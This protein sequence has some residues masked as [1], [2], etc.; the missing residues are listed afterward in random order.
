MIRYDTTQH[1]IIDYNIFCYG[2]MSNWVSKP[3]PWEDILSP[4][5]DIEIPTAC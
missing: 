5:D 4:Y 2:A 3:W 1:D